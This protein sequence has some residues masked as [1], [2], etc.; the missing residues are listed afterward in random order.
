[1]NFAPRSVPVAGAIP[2]EVTSLSYTANGVDLLVGSANGGIFRRGTVTVFCT[3]KKL[4][5]RV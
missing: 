5:C 1:M 2:G 4:R 3:V